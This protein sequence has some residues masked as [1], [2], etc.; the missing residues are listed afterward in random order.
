MPRDFSR[1]VR[2]A[3]EYIA[4][5]DVYQTNLSRQWQRHVPLRRV[6]PVA[7]YQRLRATNP[8]P[9]RGAAA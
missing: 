2:R 9:V 7:I 5:G 3:L 1:A 4:A 6:D 8:E